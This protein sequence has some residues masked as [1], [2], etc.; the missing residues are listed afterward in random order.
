MR[1]RYS[2]HLLLEKYYE[3][4]LDGDSWHAISAA[5]VTQPPV[6]NLFVEVWQ[7]QQWEYD[8]E[9]RHI[10]DLDRIFRNDSGEETTDSADEDG[11]PYD[12][13]RCCGSNRPPEPVKLEVRASHKPFVTI[14]DYLATIHPWLM[15][16]RN[17]IL[18][19]MNYESEFTEPLPEE[20][21]LAVSNYDVE[22]LMIEDIDEFKA[23]R[24]AHGTGTTVVQNIPVSGQ[25]FT[26]I[27]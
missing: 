4:S 15:S 14:H 9:D 20:T 10:K 19:A 1:D 8:W 26:T 7:F 6:T 18:L 13:I 17:T 16:Q 22:S 25:S 12:L 27:D 21:Q 24:R 5:P 2:P 3:R 11:N 23:T